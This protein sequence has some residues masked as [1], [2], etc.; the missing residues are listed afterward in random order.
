MKKLMIVL[1]ILACSNRFVPA[2]AEQ[3]SH[4]VLRYKTEPPARSFQPLEIYL[5][6]GDQPL[7]AYQFELTAVVGEVA[8][9]GVESGAHPAFSSKPPYYDPAA[10]QKGRIIIADFNIS[11]DLPTGKT[12]VATVHLMITGDTIPEYN[13]KLTVAADADGNE[14]PAQISYVQGGQK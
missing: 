2:L 8:I 14:I 1:I 13:L 4:N 10:L 7:A 9:V 12:R 6:S 3:V 5:D 11:R